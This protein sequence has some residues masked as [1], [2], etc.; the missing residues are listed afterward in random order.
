MKNSVSK[1]FCGGKAVSRKDAGNR[2]VSNGRRMSFLRN[3]NNLPKYFRKFAATVIVALCFAQGAWA[4]NAT[5]IANYIKSTTYNDLNAT[6][7]GN[8]VTVT[9]SLNGTPSNDDFLTLNIDAGVTVR[10][11]ATLT[12]TVSRYYTLIWI[13]GGSGTFEMQSGTIEN[14]S[15]GMAIYTD[16]SGAINIS[17]GTVKAGSSTAIYSNSTGVITVSGNAKITSAAS[18]NDAT[19]YLEDY[20]TSTAAR[21][22][23][24]GGTVENT[25]NAGEGAIHNCSSGAIN[26]SGGTVSANGGHA[27][28]TR[29]SSG[30]LNISG[31][32]VTATRSSI[33][34][35]T[36]YIMD[37]TINVSG[38]TVRADDANAFLYRVAR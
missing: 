21:L 20:G 19:I 7:S 15:D 37:G 32:T 33:S 1:S 14:A 18:Y 13:T 24:T 17:G 34:G 27:I 31:G 38:G 16:A 4:D 26:I 25:K 22:V 29:H 2:A 28:F 8:I 3:A 23:I 30:T 35:H 36:I 12:G 9:G 6:V 11:Q 5:T 10:W